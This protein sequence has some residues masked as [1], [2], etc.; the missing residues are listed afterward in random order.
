MGSGSSKRRFGVG[1]HFHNVIHRILTE[2][3]LLF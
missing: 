3:T 1:R 2:E